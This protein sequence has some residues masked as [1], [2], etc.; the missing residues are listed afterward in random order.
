MN[1]VTK[2]PKTD[3]GQDMIWVI[4]DRLTKS[5]HFL[6][7]KENDSMEKLTRQS[8]QVSILETQLDIEYGITHPENSMVKALLRHCYGRKCRSTYL[9][10]AEVGKLISWFT[11]PEIIRETK[12]RLSKPA[13]STS[14]Y[15]IDKSASVNETLNLKKCLS[16]ETAAD[17]VL[18]EIPPSMTRSISSLKKP[19]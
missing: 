19:C 10:G 16:D 11:R 13:S 8:L 15:V 3:S 17:S 2:L 7:A 6:P 14:F 5:A 18:D 12:R 4:V 9:L 1:S